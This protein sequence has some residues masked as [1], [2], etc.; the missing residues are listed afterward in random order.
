MSIKGSVRIFIAARGL[1]K[2]PAKLRTN[3]EFSYQYVPYSTAASMNTR[4]LSGFFVSVAEQ[5]PA[6][7]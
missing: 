3:P 5:P 2:P 1:F 4:K 6:S 7:T